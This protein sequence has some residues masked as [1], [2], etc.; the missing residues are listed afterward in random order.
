MRT[1]P[2]PILP[3][4]GPNRLKIGIL[5]VLALILYPLSVGAVEYHVSAATGSNSNP[6]SSDYPFLTIQKAADVMVAGDVCI[7][8]AGTYREEVTPAAD[9]VTFKSAPGE[10]VLV[11]GFEEVTGWSH[12]SGSIYSAS[13]GFND[14]GDRNQVLYNDQIM[15]LARWPNKTNYN[16]FDLEAAVIP[17]SSGSTT[18]YINN[19]GIPNWSWGSGGVVWFLGKSRWTSWRV[20]ATGA[21]SGTVY[22]N[23]LRC[24]KSIYTL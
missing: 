3:C 11:S 16:P 23:T 24:G 14:L 4:V 20:P 22:F 21:T 19:A 7:I 8:H 15:N 9:S 17:G 5:S 18:T 13:L 12:Y 10:T 1:L 2:K 6:G